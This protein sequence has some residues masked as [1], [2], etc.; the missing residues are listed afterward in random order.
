MKKNWNTPDVVEMNL[1]A[2]ASSAD[3]FG[4]P[5]I[6]PSNPGYNPFMPPT[7]KKPENPQPSC[8]RKPV[9]D[10]PWNGPDEES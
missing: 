9:P 10:F 4:F 7:P 2:T 6:G 8:P 3:C 1:E 5:F